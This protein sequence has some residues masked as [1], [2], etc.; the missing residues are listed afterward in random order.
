MD[1]ES[2]DTIIYYKNH[3]VLP[4]IVLI[5]YPLDE[6]EGLYLFSTHGEKLIVFVDTFISWEPDSSLLLCD[7]D[8]FYYSEG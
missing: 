4:P 6:G 7:Y 2:L 3:L 8:Y 5:S 1:D